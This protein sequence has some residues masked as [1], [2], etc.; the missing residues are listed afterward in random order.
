MNYK[1]IRG[2]HDL[3]FEDMA[4]FETIERVAI[5][6]AKMYGFNQIRT[7]IIE[8]ANVFDKN[9][10]ESSD[11]INKEMYCFEDKSGDKVVLRP[12]GT[13]PVV[14][15][16]LSNGLTHL[17]PLK[18]FYYGS[19]FRYERPQKGRQRQFHQVGFEYLGTN[20]YVSDIEV[21]NL[22]CNFLSNLNINNY[23]ILLNSL[24][25]VETL[26]NYK[27]K[28]VEYFNDYANQLSEDSKNRLKNNPLRILD[29]KDEEDKKLLQNIPI[30][31][32]F[33]NTQDND[34]F[35]NVKQGLDNLGIKYT[36]SPSLVRGLDYYTHSVF[37]FVSEDLG[38]QST[39]LAGGRYNNLINSMGGPN[40]GA[41]GFATGMERLALL[42]AN[43]NPK[44]KSIAIITMDD[45]CDNMGLALAKTIREQYD[46]AS[47]YILGKDFSNKLKKTSAEDYFLAI[48][49]GKNE[50]DTKILSIK[51]LSSLTQA[52]IELQHLESFLD[53]NY[54]E[55][56]IK[57]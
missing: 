24:G 35:N 9:L 57:E 43:T 1:N 12:E 49:I 7:P 39:I 38:A 25:S 14:R 53:A 42:S 13:A 30:I 56:K 21:I 50:L 10:G 40:I 47:S 6:I 4:K 5:K 15:A 20:S 33:F 29:S 18:F 37:E 19:M 3:Y 26:N 36:L 46:F 2:T 8:Y 32:D 41:C 22:A 27:L 51:D 54:M 48:I 52:K 44:H 55:Y 17:L 11:I 16:L 23:T 34:F 45:N 28:L 31:Y